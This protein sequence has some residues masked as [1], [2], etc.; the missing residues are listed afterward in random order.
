[1]SKWSKE[2]KEAYK[3]KVRAIL[4]RKP[5]ISKYELGSLLN[6]AP[7]TAYYL[8][9]AILKEVRESVSKEV[10]LEEIGKFQ[11]EIDALCLE[12]WDIITRN[13]REFKIE[14]YDK[15]GKP[16][17][18]DKGEQLYRIEKTVISTQAKTRAMD[19]IGKLRNMILEA[20]FNAGLFKKD[21]GNLGIDKIFDEKYQK[22]NEAIDAIKKL[23]ETKDADNGVQNR[24]G[25]DVQTGPTGPIGVRESD[26]KAIS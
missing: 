6:I 11:Q 20:K 19:L 17:L 3:D 2:T 1:M 7:E 5:R 16:S 10:I 12:A 21:W 4:V 9:E 22:M 8:K 13:T 25:E 24:E 15:D 23:R 18:N 14:L 26:S